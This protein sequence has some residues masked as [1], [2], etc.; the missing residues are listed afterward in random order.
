MKSTFGLGYF[1]EEKV[2]QDAI[3]LL[4]FQIEQKKTNKYF[5]TLSFNYYETISTIFNGLIDQ[6]SFYSSKLSNNFF[7]GLEQE[8]FS[9]QYSVPK[10]SYG[11]RKNYFFSYPMR[12]IHYSIGLYL[13]RLSSDLIDNYL[14]NSRSIKSYYGGNLKYE[15]E[16]DSI[17]LK[18]ANVYYRNHYRKF[19]NNIKKELSDSNNK[20]IIHLDIEN[21]FDNVSIKRLLDYLNRFIKHSTK[22]EMTFDNYC[23]EEITFFYRFISEEKGG[24]PQADN[25]IISGFLGYL[26][27]VF[28]DLKIDD[29]LNRIATGIITEHKIIRYVDDIYLILTFEPDI[30]I[31]IKK[32]LAVNILSQISDL[33]YYQFSLRINSKTKF[34]MLDNQDQVKALLKELKKVSSEY[35]NETISIT[36]NEDLLDEDNPQNKLNKIFIELEKIKAVSLDKLFSRNGNAGAIDEEVFKEIYDKNVVQLLNKQENK[37]KIEEIFQGFNY[38]LVNVNSLEIIQIILKNEHILNQY[39]TFLLEK[40]YI[41]TNDRDNIVEILCQTGFNNTD[42]IIKLHDDINFKPIMEL[43]YMPIRIDYSGYYYLSNEQCELV[44]ENPSIIQ[45]IELRVMNEKIGNYSVALNHL[46]NEIQAICYIK[47][48]TKVNQKNYTVIN[49]VQYLK[50][51]N[52][53]HEVIIKVQNLFDRRNNNL[54]SH[55][56]SNNLLASGIDEIE[57]NDY[58]QSVALCLNFIFY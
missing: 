25:D 28:A 33:L 51:K 7:Y 29:L 11:V 18:P 42:L 9:K 14:R 17:V 43:Y 24:I 27:L 45:Q 8:F 34:F 55:S 52:V 46:V 53:P 26:Y 57:Y 23:I 36:Y 15:S 21:Y 19:K 44:M 37:E 10:S 31:E 41:T 49:V 58:K 40:K 39:I 1:L 30:D 20:L 56:G 16:N 6:E 2:W 13:L 38:D 32:S 35:K 54:I 4:N 3:Q 22:M 5:N 48:R 47:S 12:I 50:E